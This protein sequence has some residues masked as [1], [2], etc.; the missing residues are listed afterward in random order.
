M[1]LLKDNNNVVVFVSDTIEFGTFG[2][3]QKWKVQEHLF[4]MDDNYVSETA[5]EELPEDFEDY[6]YCHTIE[7]GFYLNP[8]WTEPQPPIEDQIKQTLIANGLMTETPASDCT[9][10]EYKAYKV[11]LSK[12]QLKTYFNEHVV[13]F[14]HNNVEK[15]YSITQEKQELLQSEIFMCTL[16]DTRVPSWNAKGEVCD[17]TWTK[18]ELINLAKAIASVVKPRVLQ[19]Q[20]FETTI[21]NSTTKEA[22]DSVV[23]Q[24]DTINGAE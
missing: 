5:T 17:S 23:I 14:T 13:L 4:L 3:V 21:N 6:K 24:Y 10:E 2:G 20:T 19:Q 12:Q 18:V 8:N 1:K 7:D 16:D 15:A 22:V 11:A 9:L